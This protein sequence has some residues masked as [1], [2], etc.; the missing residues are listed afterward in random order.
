MHSRSQPDRCDPDHSCRNIGDIIRTCLSIV[1][2]CTYVAIH[3][4]VPPSRRGRKERS[5]LS[6]DIGAAIKQRVEDL[7]PQLVLFLFAL[8]A[9]E[10]IIA[11][12]LRQFLCA[13]ELVVEY[14]LH[15]KQ[16]WFAVMGGFTRMQ[17]GEQVLVARWDDPAIDAMREVDPVDIEAR[18]KADSLA[19]F[20]T[21]CQTAWFSV[22]LIVRAA[23]GLPAT[24]LEVA[25]A[26]FSLLPLTIWWLWKDKPKDVS[27]PIILR[28]E[29]AFDNSDNLSMLAEDP[30]PRL[31]YGVSTNLPPDAASA[32]IFWSG[33]WTIQRGAF[34]T[35]SFTVQALTASAFGAVHCAV[36]FSAFPSLVERW[37]WRGSALTITLLPL[38]ALLAEQISETKTWTAVSRALALFLAFYVPARIMLL[39]LPFTTL[40][41]LPSGAFIEFDWT[42]YTPHL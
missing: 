32:P 30:L 1:F 5:L 20:L 7:R 35:I 40:R 11:F 36:W 23:V 2:L 15:P 28:F 29:G 6:R 18:S 22:T 4:N 19:K 17:G 9:P 14:K 37:L 42:A 16:A 25:T 13:R 3:P 31:I 12:A 27:E 26:A 38:V 21:V 34:Y 8:V 39:V 10:I 33:S 24:E 41:A